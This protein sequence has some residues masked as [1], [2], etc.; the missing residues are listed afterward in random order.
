MSQNGNLL[1]E[2]VTRRN[3]VVLNSTDKCFGTITRSKKTAKGEEKSVID[4]IIVTEALFDHTK[5]MH[6]DENREK[7]LTNFASKKQTKSDHNIIFT[8]LDI[9]FKRNSK[10]ERIELFN[11]KNWTR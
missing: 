3:L 4:F 2:V 1:W 6:I 11:Y 8:E 9:T 5:I 7:V 10:V